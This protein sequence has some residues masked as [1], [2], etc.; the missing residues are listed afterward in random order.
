MQWLLF[1]HLLLLLRFMS[2]TCTL[3]Q[4]VV[5]DYFILIEIYFTTIY[6]FIPLLGMW[7]ISSSLVNVESAAIN[8]LIQ[9]F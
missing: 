2:V 1:L 5:V 8:I 7:V 4:C 3:V 6:F 9:T